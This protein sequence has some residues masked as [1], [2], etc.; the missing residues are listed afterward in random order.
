MHVHCNAH[1][2]RNEGPNFIKLSWVTNRRF[3]SWITDSNPHESLNRWFE[4]EL[5]V[6]SSATSSNLL[7]LVPKFLLKNITSH[8][9]SSCYLYKNEI[10]KM[11]G[12][13]FVCRLQTH[14][15]MNINLDPDICCMNIY[16]CLL[17]NGKYMIIFKGLSV[18]PFFTSIHKTW[19]ISQK[20][21][22]LRTQG[23]IA[24]NSTFPSLSS[25]KLNYSK[26]M[27][28]FPRQEL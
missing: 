24:I 25:F 6:N 15:N 14:T 13:L 16:L 7:K 26:L 4:L 2:H 28:I 27:K 12:L 21:Y 22:M 5:A 9:Q 8:K 20:L 10:N 17:H 23:N 11:L 1:S 3:K 18:T 19:F